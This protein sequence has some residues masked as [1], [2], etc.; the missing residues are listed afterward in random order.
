MSSDIENSVL[1][2]LKVSF[3]SFQGTPGEAHEDVVHKEFSRAKL[4]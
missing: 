3:L 2:Q 1:L 4:F